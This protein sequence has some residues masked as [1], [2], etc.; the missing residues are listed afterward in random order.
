MIKKFSVYHVAEF[1][2]H[3]I[4]DRGGEGWYQ[5]PHH[6]RYQYDFL[7][8]VVEHIDNTFCE[9]IQLI[10]RADGTVAAG[11]SGVTRL[12]ALLTLRNWQTIPAIVSTEILPDWLDVRAP[13]TTV[14]QFQSY[15]R[16]EPADIGFTEDGRA[17]HR[18]HNPNPVQVAAT[19]V[20]SERTRQRVITMLEEEARR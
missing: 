5:M 11:P 18:N 2:I 1:P 9:P 17:Y 3:K 13:V 6:I 8:A 16:L 10:M 12:Y 20:V 4:T 7:G 14:K 15:Y 19:M